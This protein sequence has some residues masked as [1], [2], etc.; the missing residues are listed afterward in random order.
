MKRL[1]DQP[2]AGALLVGFAAAV[3][4]AAAGASD[5]A[6]FL[7]PHAARDVK[8]VAVAPPMMVRREISVFSVIWILSVPQSLV[9]SL[10]K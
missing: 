8:S 6:E 7:D 5:F 1:Y 4:G 10:S 9:V 2:S 3:A